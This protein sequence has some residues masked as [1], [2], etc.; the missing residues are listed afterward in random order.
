MSITEPTMI[1]LSE[2]A[3]ALL[4]QM[5]EDNFLAEMADGYRLGIG[6]ALAQG[7]EPPDVPSRRT[8]FSVATIDPDKEIA[9]AIRA[10]MDLQGGSVYRM[11]ERLADW[12]V[13][14]LA[15]R[16]DG[17]PLNVESLVPRKP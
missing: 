10:L 16:F 15:N 9:S 6:L 8:V 5:K 11:A 17:G 12:G 7:V 3:H 14:E 2:R 1:G 13:F 4:Q